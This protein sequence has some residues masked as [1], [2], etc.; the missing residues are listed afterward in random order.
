MLLVMPSV[1]SRRAEY[2]ESTRDAVLASATELFCAHG[3]AST[4][5]DEVAAHARVTKGAIYHHFANKAALLT[6][7][8]ERLEL[9]GNARMRATFAE[10]AARSG[11][12]AGGLAVIDEF[13]L[14]CSDPVY[15][16]LV[17]REAPIA[18]GW[19]AWRACEE[20]YAIGMIE[21]ILGA[22]EA[23][24][25]IAGPVTG[26]L[27]SVVFGMLGSAGQLLAE[28]AVE[29]RPRVR[30]EL[31]STFGAFLAGLTTNASR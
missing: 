20:E 5:L 2:T 27:V 24:G 12:A 15:G 31:R 23:A 18:L 9:D 16:V 1:K 10:V 7:A 22:L 6:A 17:F 19:Q 25:V 13:L 8:V 14:M 3:Y 29:D 28:T 30:D 21:E 4:A 11:P 26:T